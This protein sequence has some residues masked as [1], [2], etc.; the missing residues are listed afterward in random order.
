MATDRRSFLVSSIGGLG[1]LALGSV[2]MPAHAAKFRYKLGHPYPENLPVHTQSLAA[3]KK[4]AEET[5]GQVTIDVFGN[6]A[7]GG[8]TQMISQVRSGALQFYSGAGVIVS[9]FVPLAAISG[10]GFA[11]KDYPT[12][13]SA[14]DGDLGVKIRS[15]FDA[16]GLYA[17]DTCWDTGFRQVS[18]STIPIKQPSD[19]KGFKIRVPVSR[20]YTSLFSGLGASPASVNLSEVYSALQTHIVDGQENSL[21]VFTG[22]K[23]FEVQKYVSMTNHLWDGS[24]LL[25]NGAAWK[26]LPPEFQEI[27]KR[28][29]NEAALVQRTQSEAYNKECREKV[30]STGVTVNEIDPAAFRATLQASGYY[31]DW[32]T[33]YG[34]D[35]W[36]SLE[37]YAGKLA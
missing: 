21:A 28:N 32:K 35:A 5:N 27:V 12:I 17:F 20:A 25:S 7:L 16:A 9:S 37:K 4:I 18:T 2:A 34:A 19:L 15:A 33:R 14:L 10:V 26:A 31:T 1:A 3:A 36:A 30:T 6:S 13:W 22:A 29:F 23:F 8:D 11:F 24:W